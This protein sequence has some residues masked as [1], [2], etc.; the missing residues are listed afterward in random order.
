MLKN[1]FK[2]AWRNLLKNKG[3]TAI[4]IIGLSLGIGC[5]IMISMF[6]IDELSYD[7]YHEKADRIYRINSDII[8]GGTEMSMAVSSDPMGE[9][10]KSDYP[11]VENM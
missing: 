11:E 8:F 2:I 6:V 10:L 1:Y 4:N 9:A 7:H 5:F 3:F